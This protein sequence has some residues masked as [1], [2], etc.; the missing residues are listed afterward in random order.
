MQSTIASIARFPSPTARYLGPAEVVFAAEDALRVSIDGVEIAAVAAVANY[1]PAV[2][3]TVL[4]LGDDASG[5]Y[6]IGVLHTRSRSTTSSG[7]ARF[8]HD[9]ERGCTRIAVEEGDLELVATGG[10][11]RLVA[12]GGI[13]LTGFQPVDIRSRVAVRLSLIDHIGGMLTKLGIT[14]SRTNLAGDAIRVEGE[15][16]RIAARQGTLACE[17]LNGEFDR[18]D[19]NVRRAS[20]TVDTMLTKAKNVYHRVA[21]LWQLSANRTRTVVAETSHHKA[22]R[23]YTKAVEDVKIDGQKI[24]LG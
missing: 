1:I 19:V 4:V 2:G 20:F 11:I 22:R 23:V 17:Q 10:N 16:V 5:H 24:H 9:P 8:V 6:A 12:G 15:D 14:R 21:A 3:D 13:D 18:V 7:E